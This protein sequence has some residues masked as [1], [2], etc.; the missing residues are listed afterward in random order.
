[1]GANEWADTQEEPPRKDEQA[2]VKPEASPKGETEANKREA[3]THS[4]APNSI[5]LPS[6]SLPPPLLSLLSTIQSTLRSCFP[7]APPHTAQRLAELLLYPQQHYRTLP[8]YL[9]AL[10]RIVSVSSPASL[11]PLPTLAPMTTT[12]NGRMLN[13]LSSPSLDPADKDFIGGAELTEIPWLRNIGSPTPMPNGPM[14]DLR[15][16]STSVID[17]PNGAGSVET[18]TVNVNGVHSSPSREDDG[19][20]PDITQGELLRQEHEAGVV[21]VPASIPNAR[22]TRSSTAASAAATRAVGGEVE[23]GLGTGEVEA[24]HARG[25]DVIGMEDMGPQSPGSGLAGGL[26]LEGA[27]GRRGEGESM[28]VTVGRP[29][30]GEEEEQQQKEEV[31]DGDGDTVIADADR[32]AE[33]DDAGAGKS[34]GNNGADAADTSAL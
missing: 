5:D 6:K 30:E 9:R 3:S 18:V 25:P 13:G 4:P 27:V 10:D 34:G 22:V 26:D 23:E 12:S 19:I 8:S 11:F 2:E 17:G 7:T 24:V 28:A 29:A 31:K 1:M 16:E 32:F 33:G 21:P 15:T 20:G 14:N